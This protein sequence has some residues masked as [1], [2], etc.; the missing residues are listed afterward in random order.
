MNTEQ[1]SKNIFMIIP[2]L[3]TVTRHAQ[4][5]QNNKFVKPLQYLNHRIQPPASQGE[6]KFKKW[7]KQYFFDYFVVL[8]VKFCFIY[9][10]LRG[11]TQN[12]QKVLLQ[13]W[14]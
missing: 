1:T 3:V 11:G 13:G 2:L 9:I 8:Y 5:T 4:S 7:I 14:H 12:H 6:L 10:F